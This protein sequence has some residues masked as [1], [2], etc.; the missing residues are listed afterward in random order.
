[1]ELVAFGCI[2]LINKKMI[3]IEYLYSKIYT[4]DNGIKI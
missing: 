4:T 2:M 1:M 3:T